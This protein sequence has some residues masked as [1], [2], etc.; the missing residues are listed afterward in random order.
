M[1]NTWINQEKQPTTIKRFLQKQGVGHRLIADIKHGQ[2]NF[3]R[4]GKLVE[5]VATVQ[6]NDQIS[7]ELMPEKKD[8]EVVTSNLPI[9]IIYE[10]ENWLIVNKPAGLTSIPGPTNRVDTLLNRIKGYLIQQG[11]VDLRPHLILRLDRFT[12]GLVLVAKHR[13]AQSMISTQ[14]EHHLIEKIYTAIVAGQIKANHEVIK[15][16]IGRVPDSPKRAVMATGQT[17][18]TEFWVQQRSPE[19]TA[20]RVQLHT[21]RTHQIRVHLTYLGYPLLGDQLYGGPQ[22]LI[23]RQALHATSLKFMDPFTNQQV[24]VL[25]PLPPDMVNILGPK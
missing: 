25:A 5:S 18:I 1:K 13:L 22:K 10:D 2:G 21:G 8:D 12:S 24:A 15:E 9:E 6:E 19:W 20:L 23:L 7:I 4:N 3:F 16:P 11:A 17:A 14:V